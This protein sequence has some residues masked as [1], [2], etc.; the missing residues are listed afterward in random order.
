[1][2]AFLN[3][4]GI[5]T[6]IYYPIPITGQEGFSTSNSIETTLAACKDVLSLPVHPCVD[7]DDISYII[8]TIGE[9]YD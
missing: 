9:F 1:M 8:A 5:G 7:R 3:E 2:A 4:Q 6:G